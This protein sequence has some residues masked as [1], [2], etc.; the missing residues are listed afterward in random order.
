MQTLLTQV[1]Q[2]FID[3]VRQGR[4]ERLKESPEIFSGL[5]WTGTESVKLGLADDFGSDEYVA[6]E[7]VGVEKRVDF[8]LQEHLLDKLTG[9][10]GVSFGRGFSS[11]LQG[12]TLR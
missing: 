11:F 4:G 3:A 9:K 12:M 7:I 1:H 10:F 8:T 5:V 6:R 2:Q